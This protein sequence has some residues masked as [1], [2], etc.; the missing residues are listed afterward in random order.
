MS[1][2]VMWIMTFIIMMSYL[3]RT[4]SN[5]IM[6]N[7]AEGNLPFRRNNFNVIAL[8]SDLRYAFLCLF[9]LNLHDQMSPGSF[10]SWH[11]VQMGWFTSSYCSC[12]SCI[13]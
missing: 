2:N 4:E 3:Y 13:G 8:L 1:K 6:M 10:S 7:I 5:P 11:P 9:C 12:R